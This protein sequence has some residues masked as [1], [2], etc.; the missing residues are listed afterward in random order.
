LCPIYTIH[1][2]V[3]GAELGPAP[4]EPDSSMQP[5]DCILL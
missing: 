3:M 4:A 5:E 2:R 1:M